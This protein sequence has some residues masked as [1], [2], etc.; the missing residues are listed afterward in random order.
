MRENS[1]AKRDIFLISLSGLFSVVPVLFLLMFFARVILIRHDLIWIW[2]P[3]NYV[4][5]ASVIVVPI[6]AIIA[7]LVMPLIYNAINNSSVVST[8]RYH[9]PLAVLAF[10]VPLLL[11]L[12]FLNEFG[13]FSDNSDVRNAILFGSVFPFMLIGYLTLLGVAS[14]IK[15]RVFEGDNKKQSYALIVSIAGI[16]VFLLSV[17]LLMRFNDRGEV[18]NI[19]VLTY[20]AIAASILVLI[21]GVGL[22]AGSANYMPRFIRLEAPQKMT[23]K[24]RYSVFYKPFLKGGNWA[25][26]LGIFFGIL[27]VMLFVFN[28]LNYAQLFLLLHMVTPHPPFSPLYYSYLLFSFIGFIVAFF[29]SLIISQKIITGANSFYAKLLAMLLIANAAVLSFIR[30]FAAFGAVNLFMLIVCFVFMGFSAGIIFTLKDLS[31][32]EVCMANKNVTDGIAR[33]FYNLIIVAAIAVSF[34]VVIS[35]GEP[36]AGLA[37]RSIIPI[38]IFV[39]L[40][41]YLVFS[42]IDKK[43][44]GLEL[45]ID[46]QVEI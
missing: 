44:K 39:C 24:K 33:S 16:T 12:V 13:Y 3:T 17:F 31:I 1:V 14:S 45:D 20:S 32:D 36:Q 29:I 9:V 19:Y 46:E 4:L 34:I 22:Y 2:P 18:F 41:A 5:A 23:V 43:Q 35:L 38:I 6:S 7:F 25:N 42:M 21:G 8:G 40:I 26:T 37:Q 11:M 27:A 15:R 28:G 30:Y 10:S